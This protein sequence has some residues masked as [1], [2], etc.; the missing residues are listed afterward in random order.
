M[1]ACGASVAAAPA[2]ATVAIAAAVAPAVA[3]AAPSSRRKRIA[4]RFRQTRH[5]GRVYDHLPLRARSEALAAD[6][7]LIP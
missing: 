5:S 6:F 7:L 1:T 4:R 3:A 2:A